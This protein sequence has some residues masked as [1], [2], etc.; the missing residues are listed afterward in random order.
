MV[1]DEAPAFFEEVFF[2][3][4]VAF[5][6]VAFFDVA[7]FDDAFFDVAFFDAAFLVLAFFDVFPAVFFVEAIQILLPTEGFG[8]HFPYCFRL[9]RVNRRWRELAPLVAAGVLVA[10]IA[11]I[12]S[13]HFP[14][15]A[16]L[17]AT[18]VWFEGDLRRVYSNMVD[19]QSDHYRSKVHPLFSI[20]A[21]VMTWV[22][23]R[24]LSI[25]PVLSV[26]L[27]GAAMAF[28]W[29][30]LLFLLLRAVTRSPWS[31][32]LLTLLGAV[33][34]SFVFWATVPET[35]IFGSASILFALLAATH[36]GGQAILPVHRLQGDRQDC[37]SSTTTA[38]IAAT[39]AF[40]V[41]NVMA[42]LATAIATLP[43]RRALQ[44]AANALCIVV[45]LWG[46]QK[47]IIP[48]TQFFIGDKEE[49]DYMFRLDAARVASV[50]RSFVVTSMV[51]PTPTRE[52]RYYQPEAILFTQRSPVSAWPAVVFW[53]ALLLLGCIGLRAAPELRALR[54]A[55]LLTLAGQFVLHVVYG[56]ETF[57][58]SLHFAPL[59]VV[60]AAFAF[61]TRWKVVAYVLAAVLLVT[62]AMNN[63]RE[64][65][66]ARSYA[67]TPSA[68][69]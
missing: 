59:L 24:A 60:L 1:V 21:Y 29:G 27:V 25:D 66:A 53:L 39:L 44:A 30:L 8:R 48:S 69:R 13:K 5:F 10:A 63:A 42:G 47:Y 55:L 26:R 11:F 22:P 58:Y 32:L 18:D 61:R 37:L 62:A 9:A 35:Y 12:G 67:A 56:E 64:F 34:A 16:Y 36:S 33:S 15:S 57:L 40:T 51:M 2:E 65:N 41:T 7:F 50:A 17:G 38:A 45:L 31:A 23:R 19:R 52:T 68:A 14:T 3:E 20:V 4:L 6:D 43:W 49:K 46:V 28:V 54:I